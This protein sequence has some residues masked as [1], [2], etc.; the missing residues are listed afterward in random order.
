MQQVGLGAVGHPSQRFGQVRP[1]RE[2]AEVVGSQQIVGDLVVDGH[3][4]GR[5]FTIGP[6]ARS[7]SVNGDGVGPH[8]GI[9]DQ[10]P[11]RIAAD[12]RRSLEIPRMTPCTASQ[13]I[14]C[15]IGPAPRR[16]VQPNCGSVMSSQRTELVIRYGKD[17]DIGCRATGPHPRRGRRNVRRAR[18]RR[19][20]DAGRRGTRRRRAVGP[21]R[22]FRFQTGTPHHGPRTTCRAV[23]GPLTAATR[24]RVGRGVGPREHRELLRVRRGG[25]VHVALPAP[26]SAGRP[27]DRRGRVRRSPTAAP[28][29]SPISSG[30]APRTPSR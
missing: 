19:G 13:W 9:G 23:E 8:G 28:Q 24:G 6:V 10:P 2:D 20:E 4:D 17:A 30:S 16:S 1:H 12:G 14:R 22:P 27:G 3:V 25:P 26:G 18:V 11:L 29:A 5:H 7:S 15:L 21:L